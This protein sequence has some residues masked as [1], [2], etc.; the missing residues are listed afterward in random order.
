[1]LQLDPGRDRRDL[2]REHTP[3]RSGRWRPGRPVGTVRVTGGRMRIGVI[4]SGR[5]GGTLGR[6][7][8]A[9]GHEVTYGWRD[10]TKPVPD[11]LRHE[12]GAVAPVAEAVGGAD[13]VI[14]STPWAAAEAA[15]TAIT[16]FGGKPLLDCTNP[17]GPGLTL[18]HGHTD[19]GGEQVQR[20]APTARVVK[21]FNTTGMENM[22][23]PRYGEHAAAMLACG[24]DDDAVAVG[25][26]LATDLGFEALP[27]GPLKN[28]RLLEPMALVWIDLAMVRGQGRGFAFGLLRR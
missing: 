1:M 15:L 2:R 27:F 5:I 28:A 17:I 13:V 26:R 19:S 18:T 25:V 20:W 7:L 12:R 8:A 16:D 10:P 22:A 9:A 21:V 4:G 23:D 6:G 11:D 24:D 14:L 3:G